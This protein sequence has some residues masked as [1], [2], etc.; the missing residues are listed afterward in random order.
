MKLIALTLV[1][2]FAAVSYAEAN[3]SEDLG[4][5]GYHYKVGIPTANKIRKLEEQGISG[6]FDRIVGGAI[7]DISQVPYQVGLVINLLVILTSVCGGTVLSNTRVLTAAHCYYDGVVSSTTITTVFGSNLLFSGGVRIDTTDVAVHPNWNPLTISNDIAVIRVTPV[8]FS[9]VIQPIALPAGAELNNNFVGVNA[10]A[11]GYGLTSDGGS[12]SLGQRLSSVTLPVITNGEC[13]SVYGNVI[14]D[15][16]LCTSGNG[17]RG[18]CSGDS[19]GP[20]VTSSSGRNIL[21]G[22]VSFGARAGCEA[23]LPAGYARVTSYVPW[24]LNQ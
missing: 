22:V 16:T 24:I 23:G 6:G 8:T 18:T 15:S 20:L 10:L 7:T 14:I 17:G 2:A 13:L 9:N 11:S 19:G 5:Y 12:I 21:I 3:L 4:V 1:L